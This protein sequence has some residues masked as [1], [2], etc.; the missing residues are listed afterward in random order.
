MSEPFQSAYASLYDSLYADKEYDAEVDLL[1]EIFRRFLQA[2]TA[3]I[4]DLGCGTGNHALRLARRGYSVTGVDRSAAMLDVARVKSGEAGLA[5]RLVEADISSYS[6]DAHFDAALMMFAVLSYQQANDDVRTTLD[7]VRRHL[8]PGGLLIFDV[9]HG[10]GVLSDPP[11]ERTKEVDAGSEG[12]VAR[13]AH[14]TLDV[15]RSLCRIE[16]DLSHLNGEVIGEEQHVV[17][18]FFPTEVELFLQVS[19]FEMLSITPFGALDS[20]VERTTWNALVVA[21]ASQ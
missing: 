7:T 4:L 11:V 3:T 14:P 13:T 15:R 17:R 9:W 18:F 6:I 2:R 19:G 1:E 16:Y 21:R 8:R 20:D 10:P 5:V 12:R